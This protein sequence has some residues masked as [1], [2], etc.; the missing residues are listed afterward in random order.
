M[1]R[2]TSHDRPHLSGDHPWWVRALPPLVVAGVLTIT[3]PETYRLAYD[4]L[5]LPVP[6]LTSAALPLV[7]DGYAVAAL[8]FHRDRLAALGLLGIMVA[9]SVV[10]HTVGAENISTAARA[11]MAVVVVGVIV[12][13]MARVHDLIHARSAAVARVARR[14]AKAEEPAPEP[15]PE[16]VP[17]RPH[18][19]AVQSAPADP[20]EPPRDEATLDAPGLPAAPWPDTPE[21]ESWAAEWL[22]GFPVERRTNA[23]LAERSGWLRTGARV[24]RLVAASR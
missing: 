19:V 3:T 22:S 24:R 9:M 15:V 6:V 13:I 4:L 12:V 5:G 20:P 21:A 17:E 2:R 16:V 11:A 10:M 23:A 8:R 7:I 14:K 1:N 18:L